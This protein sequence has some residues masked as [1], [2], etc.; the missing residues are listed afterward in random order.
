MSRRTEL[1]IKHGDLIRVFY[2]DIHADDP[3]KWDGPWYGIVCMTPD[4][5]AEAVWQMWCIE[6]ATY[7]ILSPYRDRIEV[8]SEA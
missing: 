3:D 7:H 4:D 8:V 2:P 6:R 5:H 1:N